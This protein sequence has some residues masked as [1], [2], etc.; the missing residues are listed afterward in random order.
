MRF[1]DPNCETE[2]EE[3]EQEEEAVMVRP[4]EA[5]LVEHPRLQRREQAGDETAL[6]TLGENELA[7]DQQRQRQHHLP[8]DP[9]GEALRRAMSVVVRHGGA[10][11]K[12]CFG[13]NLQPSGKDP[14]NASRRDAF[15]TG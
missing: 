1:I 12:G 9:C 5:R 15:R 4:A 6:P 7:Q 13:P 10:G 3:E 2:H 8:A 14:I 11:R